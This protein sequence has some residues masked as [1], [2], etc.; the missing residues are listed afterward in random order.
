MKGLVLGRSVAALAATTMLVATGAV[1]AVAAT[2]HSG[3]VHVCEGPAGQLRAVPD[4]AECRP[5]ERGHSLQTGSTEGREP[6]TAVLPLMRDVTVLVPCPGDTGWGRAG[7]GS[8]FFRHE[9][10]IFAYSGSDLPADVRAEYLIDARAGV[11]VCARVFDATV[12]RAVPESQACF[13]GGE[14]PPSFE[15][16][17]TTVCDDDGRCEDLNEPY[18]F[19][20]VRS[21][22]LRLLPGQ[23]HELF[24]ETWTDTPRLCVDDCPP[25]PFPG[26]V[27][28]GVLI[29]VSR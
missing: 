18:W 5:R 22:P 4:P 3:P 9:R 7:C 20:R 8:D 29:A 21:A 2:T 15:I 1:V 19:R 12:G 14:G 26:R 28:R 10:E 27:E 24:V 11:T 16:G 13:T 25:E 23:P 17:Y 6:T